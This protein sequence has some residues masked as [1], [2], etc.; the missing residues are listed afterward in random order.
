VSPFEEL[1]L[2]MVGAGVGEMV[3]AGEMTVVSVERERERER[4]TQTDR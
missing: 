2:G 1:L 4:V 3:G